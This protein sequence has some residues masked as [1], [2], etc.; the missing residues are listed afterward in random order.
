MGK[1]EDL[2]LSPPKTKKLRSN[3]SAALLTDMIIK[4][5]LG[6][7][8]LMSLFTFCLIGIRLCVEKA[9]CEIHIDSKHLKSL[10]N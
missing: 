1:K 8:L 4:F 3:V 2:I 7:S 5:I 9:S 6:K 10:Y